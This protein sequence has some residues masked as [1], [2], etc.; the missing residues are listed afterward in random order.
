M[1]EPTHIM[2]GVV[3]GRI[4]RWRHY[5]GVSIPL[6]IILA[7]LLHG[8]FDKLGLIT[9]HPAT[10]DFTD[11]FWLGYQVL[12]ALSAL[13]LL[14][15]FWGEYK[16]AIVFSLIPDIDWIVLHTADAFHKEVIFYKTPLMHDALNYL[17]DNVIP[18][19]YLNALPDLRTSEWACVIEFA[20]FGL[21]V[22]VYRLLVSRRRNIH[23]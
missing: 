14:Y 11:P 17:L 2:A 23:F 19:S 1:Q 16:V 18:F 13:V 12:M 9:Y 5:R 22:L 4:F 10:T 21:L 20:F 15:M 3:L 8:I 7:L 6:T